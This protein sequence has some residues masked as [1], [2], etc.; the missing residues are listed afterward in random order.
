MGYRVLVTG[1]PG[2]GKTTLCRHLKEVLGCK[3]L[4]ISS[5]IEKKKLFTR[6]CPVYDTLEYDSCAVEEYLRKKMKEKGSYIVDTHDPECVSFVKFDVIVVLSADPGVLYERYRKRGYNDTK[7]DENLQV[8]IMEVVYNDVIECVCEDEEE[9]SRI[10]R[11]ETA[12]KEKTKTLEEI[13][14]E[15]SESPEWSQIVRSTPE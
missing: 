9:V 2:V 8:E 3:H 13:L 6:K 1:T 10:I 12:S 5:I 4:E 14:K 15:I 7:T 11:V